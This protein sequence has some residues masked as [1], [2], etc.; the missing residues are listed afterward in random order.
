MCHRK[1]CRLFPCITI[2]RGGGGGG[3][4]SVEKCICMINVK[5]AMLPMRSVFVNVKKGIS[6]FSC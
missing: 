5:N 2:F 3:L 4:K 1:I 6:E